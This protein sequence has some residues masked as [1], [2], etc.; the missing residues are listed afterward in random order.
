MNVKKIII[1]HGTDGNPQACWYPWLRNKLEARGYQVSVPYFPE[2]NKEPIDTFIKKVLTAHTI[3]GE[4]VL[5]GHSGGAALV[6]SVLEH[7]QVQVP[8]AML[9]AGYSTRPNES[10][11]PVLQPTYDWRKMRNNV[12]D[13]YIINSVN[14]P[15]G[16]D[17]KQGRVLFDNLGGTQIVC[18]EGH[19]GDFDQHYPTFDLLEKLIN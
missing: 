2:M 13:I 18:D 15:Y 4:T 1:F 3:D 19:F 7:I 10:E 16:C 14:D 8:Q 6:L 17:E 9:V 11:E 12:R 5:I